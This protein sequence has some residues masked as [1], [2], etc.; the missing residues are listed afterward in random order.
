MLNTF[1][2]LL[3]FGLLAPL[4]LRLAVGAMFLNAGVKKLRRRSWLA[5]VFE[6]R[7]LGLAAARYAALFGLIEC[8]AGLLLIVGFLTQIAALI[9]AAIATFGL[10]QKRTYPERVPGSKG[11]FLLLLVISLSLLFSGAGFWAF[12]LPL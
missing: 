4:I 6:R 8:A 3:S 9:A 5:D 1:P 2:L 10:Y 11:A 7:G 12:D